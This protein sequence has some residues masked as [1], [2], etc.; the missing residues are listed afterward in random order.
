MR[1]IWFEFMG[2]LVVVL[3]LCCAPV[4]CGASTRDI[5]VRDAV[6]MVNTAAMGLETAQ[7]VSVSLYREEQLTALQASLQAGLPKA[8]AQAKV[9]AIR[10]QWLHVWAAFEKARTCHRALS[11][12]VAAGSAANVGDITAATDNLVAVMNEIQTLLGHSRQRI[13]AMA[14]E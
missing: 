8:Q 11:D 3:G 10:D 5:I 7:D 2:I 14:V 6:I 4:G 12:L 9:Q 1:R 13:S